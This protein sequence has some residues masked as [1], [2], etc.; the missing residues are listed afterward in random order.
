MSSYETLIDINEAESASSLENILYGAAASPF[1]TKVRAYLRYKNIPFEER[2]A[3]ARAMTKVIQ[4]R[5][6]KMMIP[7]VITPQDECVQ[8]SSC[9]I[10]H[11]E[12]RFSQ[13]SIYPSSPKQKLVADLLE[14]FGDEW[15]VNS[16]MH[17][18]WDFGQSNFW[19]LINDLGKTVTNDFA[20]FLNPLVGLAPYFVI[21]R[22]A[23]A[24][25]GLN[26]A[27]CRGIEISFVQLIKDLDEHFENFPY[28]LGGRPCIADFSLGGVFAA[29]LYRDPHPKEIID[30][31]APN[32][33]RWIKRVHEQD[34]ARYGNFVPNDD[35]PDTLI[36]ILKRMVAEQFPVLQTTGDKIDQ[37]V[38]QRPERKTF[39]RIIGELE[40]SIEGN[41]GVRKVLPYPYWMFQRCLDIYDQTDGE[42]RLKLDELL[43]SIDGEK[44]F[45][46]QAKTKLIYKDYKLRIKT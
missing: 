20:K 26:E 16:A 25:L 37:W 44:A 23:R 41:T 43:R 22:A 34:D 4:P 40:F 32:L 21:S 31:N 27:V 30:D 29:C 39:P 6:G 15:L 10:E 17:F 8:D 13:S 33:I 9:I 2:D 7:V 19:F 12:T 24:M 42:E 1:A 35:I 38:S 36:P 5:T 11:F 45:Q 46:N 18:R 14:C 3:S 28:L